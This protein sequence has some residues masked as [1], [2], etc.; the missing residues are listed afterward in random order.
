[1]SVFIAAASPPSFG[2][3]LRAAIVAGLA[4][5]LVAG[6]FHLVV[7]EP[8]IDR[9]IALESQLADTGPSEPPIVDRPTQKAGLLVGFVALGLVW[10]TLLAVAHR[11]GDRWVPGATPAGRALTLGGLAY[12]AAGI[13]P[14]LASPA[15]PPG[16]GDPATIGA[17]QA[18]YVAA[19]VASVA[20]AALAIAAGRS[21]GGP[22]GW[23]RTLAVVAVLSLALL[24]LLPR[25]ATGGDMP[26]DLVLGFRALSAAGLTL[27]WGALAL[28]YA[29]GVTRTERAG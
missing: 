26:A 10:G 5:G 2:A 21:A 13:M 8:V 29:Y 28:V 22:F 9:A 11:V 25:P 14:F 12:W 3:L 4:A 1:M 15:D 6:L 16:V 20:G 19:L 7:T 23:A 17:R 18:V 24:L 27:F